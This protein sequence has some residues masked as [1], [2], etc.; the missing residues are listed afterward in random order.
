MDDLKCR[1]RTKAKLTPQMV[2]ALNSIDATIRLDATSQIRKLLSAVVNPPI[3]EIIKS[4]IVPQ[5]VH[6][7]EDTRYP[8]LHFE[9]TWIL[10]NVVSGNSEQTQVVI[11]A[12]AIPVLIQ[13][14]TTSSNADVIEQAVWALG[15]ISADSP[16][17][18]DIVLN[19][20]LV[21]PLLEYASPFFVSL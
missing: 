2:Q 19:N 1:R 16:Q 20:N 15:N 11:E 5:I 7:L 10:T 8:E 4:G 13:L 21:P 9:S 6:F 12:G 17:T 3:D 18:R 14:L